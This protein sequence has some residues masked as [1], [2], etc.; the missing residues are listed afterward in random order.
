MTTQT[1]EPAVKVSPPTAE[2]REIRGAEALMNGG[3]DELTKKRKAAE[4]DGGEAAAEAPAPAPAGDGEERAGDGE[5]EAAEG[6]DK[7]RKKKARRRARA[8]RPRR[9]RAAPP[10]PCL[11]I[12][13]TRLVV[14]P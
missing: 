11:F 9:A 6:G 3:D 7:K 12:S 8:P 14:P 1:A 13:G 5:E 4:V 2:A 10:P